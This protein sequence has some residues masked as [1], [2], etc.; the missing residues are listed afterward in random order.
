MNKPKK[1]WTGDYVHKFTKREVLSFVQHYYVTHDSYPNVDE[2]AAKLGR[3]RKV[4][5]QF[6]SRYARYGILQAFKAQGKKTTYG[7]GIN[8]DKIDHLE[9]TDFFRAGTCPHCSHR[10]VLG[11][12]TNRIIRYLCKWCGRSWDRSREWTA[13]EVLDDIEVQAQQTRKQWARSPAH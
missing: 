8:W 12:K 9:W 3:P 2:I 4:M 11:F 6:M 5:A 1:P 10:G 7:P 13:K